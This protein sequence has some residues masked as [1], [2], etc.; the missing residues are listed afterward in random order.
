[1]V[2]LDKTQIHSHK[3]HYL[4]CPTLIINGKD[5]FIVEDAPLLANQLITNSQLVFV[6]G[7]GHYPYIENSKIFFR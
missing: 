6:E 4:T 1:M 2:F 3:W 7:S 5:D